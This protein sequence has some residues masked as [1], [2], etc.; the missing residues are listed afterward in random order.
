METNFKFK[1]KYIL[2]LISNIIFLL[3]N[4]GIQYV[5]TRKIS[6]EEYGNFYYL[7]NIMFQIVIFFDMGTSSFYFN[8]ISINNEDH[9]VEFFYRKIIVFLTFIALAFIYILDLLNFSEILF[10]QKSISIIYLAMIHAL[11][12]WYLQIFSQKI[13]AL[14]LTIK[15]E[16]IKIVHKIFTFGI[17]LIIVFLNILSFIVLFVYFISIIL[18]LLL[19][20]LIIINNSRK[21]K[22]NEFKINSDDYKTLLQEFKSFS[23]PLLISSVIGIMINIFDRW[24]L[25]FNAGSIEQG[26]FSLS[27]QLSSI[28]LI[29][30]TALIPLFMN[31]VAKYY[32]Q[33]NFSNL[34]V[35]FEKNIALF[36]VISAYFSI[37][38]SFN[39]DFLIKVIAGDYFESASRVLLILA[40]YPIHQTYGQ[41]T[42]AF[43]LATGNT[44]I[45]RNLSIITFLISIPLTFIFIGQS[46]ISLNL[47]SYG[48]AI[49]MVIVQF[50]IVN[51]QLYFVTRIVNSKFLKNLLKQIIILGLIYLIAIIAKNFIVLFEI[52]NIYINFLTNGLIYTLIIFTLII[53]NPK[54]VL[55][56]DRKEIFKFMH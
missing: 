14:Q 52:K 37:Y 46:Q 4:L 44:K 17:L 33:K 49:K 45:F 34:K 9:K 25:Q 48:L 10:N 27:T 56:I 16:K 43:L 28:S 42:G 7:T 23:F 18:V 12:T 39:A 35:I 32:S 1:Q 51:I 15:F 11:L 26:Y 50:F 31:R 30:T 3:S 53:I 22:L 5:L 54:F 19:V 20:A 41:I 47:G 29:F 36:F 24:Y 8:K 21:Q 2:K 40:I 6:P 13:D 55:N 38:L